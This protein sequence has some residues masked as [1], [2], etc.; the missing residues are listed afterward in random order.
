MEVQEYIGEDGTNA[1]EKWFDKLNRMAAVKVATARARLESGNTSSIKWFKGI[2]EYKI[3]WGP[4]Y[5]IYL[6]QEGQELIILFGGGTKRTQQ[7]DIAKAQELYREYKRR[8]RS[9]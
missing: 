1:Y 5:R 7:L 9:K 4:G 2:G 6:V 8:K 3:D